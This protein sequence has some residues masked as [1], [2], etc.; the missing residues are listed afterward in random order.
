MAE[1]RSKRRRQPISR[2]PLF[3]AIVALWFGAL[4]GLGSLALSPAALEAMVLAGHVD[5]LIPAT[6]PPLGMTARLLLALALGT[7]GGAL[8]W[9]LARRAAT[10]A[11]KPAPQVLRMADIDDRMPWPGM[12]E[13][14]APALD[15]SSFAP[16][17]FEEEPAPTIQPEATPVEEKVLPAP[18]AAERIAAAELESLSHVELVERLA[19]ALQRRQQ[20]LTANAEQT[21]APSDQ[22]VRFPAST[23]RQGVRLAP[24]ERAPIPAPAQTENALREALA[25]L[26]RMSG[27]A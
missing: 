25:A 1:Y 11:A 23:D 17:V 24:P 14:P 20:R 16:E 6:A 19:I 22:V 2:H 3:P 26:Q 18:T 15:P 5:A 27:S 21:P 4:L 13:E 12:A 7:A 8:G 9:W 10:A